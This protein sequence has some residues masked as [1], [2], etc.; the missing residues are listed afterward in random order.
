MF[1]L[2]YNPYDWKTR[3]WGLQGNSVGKGYLKALENLN[4]S[5]ISKVER[6]NW[7]PKVLCCRTPPLPTMYHDVLTP[8]FMSHK[9]AH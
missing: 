6:E 5:L 1:L 9:N 2:A 7:L 3:V 4:L 8:V